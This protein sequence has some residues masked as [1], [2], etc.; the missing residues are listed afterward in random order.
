[1]INN[2]L[3]PHLPN[4]RSPNCPS[5]ISTKHYFTRPFHEFNLTHHL[6]NHATMTADQNHLVLP[7]HCFQGTRFFFVTPII[8]LHYLSP[9][10]YFD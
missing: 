2:P 6:V 1:M 9:F 7:F 3:K 4:H 10:A 8:L 5:F